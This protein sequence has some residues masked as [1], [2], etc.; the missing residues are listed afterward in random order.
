MNEA[1]LGRAFLG[2]ALQHSVH[3]Y[4]LT[5]HSTTKQVPY[6]QFIGREL[7]TSFY[8]RIK[9]FGSTVYYDSGVGIYLGLCDGSIGTTSLIL[10]EK[11]NLIRW[12]TLACKFDETLLTRYKLGSL[13]KHFLGKK[14][15]IKE[16]F[17]ENE[18]NIG[19]DVPDESVSLVTEEAPK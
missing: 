3:L 16:L 6:A 4:N 8:K 5:Y 14:V 12:N 19:L 7:D 15:N 1:R 9:A 2:E 17:E 10:N 18:T 13:Q 11:G